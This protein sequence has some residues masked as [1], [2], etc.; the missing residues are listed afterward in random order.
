MVEE[1]IVKQ[2]VF[3]NIPEKKRSVGKP[4][5]RWLDDAEDDLK[6]MGFRG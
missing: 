4:R 5:K 2:K 1:R 6:Q 3:V